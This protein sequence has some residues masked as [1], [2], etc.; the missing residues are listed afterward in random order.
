MHAERPLRRH[1]TGLFA[2]HSYI[3]ID[4]RIR[5]QAVLRHTKLERRPFQDAQFRYGPNPSVP[6]QPATYWSGESVALA[7][8]CGSRNYLELILQILLR[9]AL[10]GIGR[11]ERP[12]VLP[13]RLFA[14]SFFHPTF[15]LGRTI[16]T[17]RVLASR[18]AS[19]TACV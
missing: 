6:S 3:R 1:L 11:T 8:A 4:F 12:P 10:D 2:F 9:K 14:A 17:T 16:S 7:E 18:I 15:L 5:P 13:L 19:A